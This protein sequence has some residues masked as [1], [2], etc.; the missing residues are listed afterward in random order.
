MSKHNKKNGGQEAPKNTIKQGGKHPE[1]G[2][3]WR[4]IVIETDG[5]MVHIPENTLAG[6]LELAAV[7]NYLVQIVTQGGK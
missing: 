2:R 3:E 5:N 6:N 1:T 4:K 7:L